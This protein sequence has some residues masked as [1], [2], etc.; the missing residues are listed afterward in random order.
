MRFKTFTVSVGDPGGCEEM[1]RFLAGHRVLTVQREFIQNGRES[2]WAFCIEYLEAA[3][4][5]AYAGTR[6]EKVDYKEVL[7][8]AQ[9]AV[10]SRLRECRKRLA[11][12]EGLPAFAV[13]TDEQLAAI[14][15]LEQL[16]M[17]S[18][19]SIKGIGDAKAAR[20]GEALIQSFAGSVAKETEKIAAEKEGKQ[21]K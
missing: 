9:F 20:Y 17:A 11:A 21:Q 8:P 1:N 10:F 3:P 2:C 15:R 18:L 19:K 5:S 12:Q 4:S 14:S 7:P 13:C 16:T 6:R